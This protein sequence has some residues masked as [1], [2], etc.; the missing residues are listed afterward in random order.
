V[1]FNT[2]Y[3][4]QPCECVCACVYACVHVCAHKCACNLCV[5]ACVR[6]CVRMRACDLVCVCVSIGSGSHP[7]THL[8]HKPMWMWPT[9]DPLL[10]NM[11]VFIFLGVSQN[12]IKI[13]IYFNCNLLIDCI[14]PCSFAVRFI[15]FLSEQQCRVVSELWVC[16]S[17]HVCL[18][19]LS[20]VH[21]TFSAFN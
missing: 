14:M 7:V 18:T 10:T 13:I 5:C 11:I 8:T 1:L 4:D 17:Y 19:S 3:S 16:C 6:V 2:S 21:G 20:V 9:H 15:S 12:E